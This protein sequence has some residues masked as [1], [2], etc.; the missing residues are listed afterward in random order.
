MRA[1]VASTVCIF[2]I[3]L[4]WDL[5]DELFSGPQTSPYNCRCQDSFGA[6]LSLSV[7]YLLSARI[8]CRQAVTRSILSLFT[9][10]KSTGK[11]FPSLGGLHKSNQGQLICS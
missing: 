8:V 1:T 9:M 11:C 2:L 10:W 7:G 6:S 5:L 4:H 3:I